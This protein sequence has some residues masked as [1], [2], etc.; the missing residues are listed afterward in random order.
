M[1]LVAPNYRATTEVDLGGDDS[2]QLPAS[3]PS[4][5]D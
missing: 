4:Y 2:I 5:P 1:L 3:E